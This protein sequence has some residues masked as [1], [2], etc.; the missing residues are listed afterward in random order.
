MAF[1]H[2]HLIDITEYSEEDIKLILETAKA[3]SEV[4]ER[5]IKKVP[6]LKGKTIVN[7]F[8]EPSTR[9]AAPSSSPR[10]AFRPTASTLAA[11]RPP[12]SR[13][14]ALS[15][16]SRPSTPIRS[17]ASLCATSTPVLPYIVTQNSPASVICAGDGKH[18]HPTQ[19]L[20]DLY[21]IWEHKGDFHGLKV[22]VVG[23][24]AH[25]RVCG[26]LIPALKIM[27][28][29]TYAVAP[30][31]AAAAGARGPGLRPR[32]ERP[33][34]R[35][36]RAGRRLHAARAAAGAPR[37]CPVPH[38]SRVP[39]ALRP[40]Q[41]PRE[42]HEARRDHLPPGPINRGVEF[43][44]YMADHP[45]RSVILEQV[46]AGICV[47]M[48]ILY[49]L[50]EVPIMALLLK[51]AHVVDPSVELDGVV[52][53]LIDGDKIAEVGENLAV[54]GAEVRDLSGKYLVPGLVDMHVHLREP[55]YEVKEDIESGTRAAAKGGFTG[56]CAMP[57]TDPVT[58]NG[59]VVEFVKSRAAEVG[60]CRVYPSGAMTRGLK[61]EAMS[62]MGDMV[63]HG[64]VAFTDD[65]RG[66][67]GA[68]MLRR[69]MDYG[70]M[71]G[72]VFMSHCRDEDLVGHGQ[73]NE[74][75][76]STR[77]A[78]EG[79]PA[80]GEELQIARDIEIAKLTGAKL[81]IQHIST[82][83]GLEIVRA[84]KA[85][86]V[87]VTCEA[88]PHHMFLTENDLDETY[89]TS[90]QGQPA[91]AYRGGCRGHSSGRH[92]RHRRRYRHRSRSPHPVGEGPRVRACALW[93]DRPRDLAVARTHRAGQ[94]GQDEHGPYGR[95]HGHQAA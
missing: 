17:T 55:G 76:V 12:R 20:L 81:H 78:L 11:P 29:E 62:E 19:A 59:T 83:H 40:D 35:P 27:G 75:K 91:A 6:T 84:G 88:T 51:N 41:G 43:D 39:Q 86:G 67:Q 47:R 71:F 1:N 18:N 2:K 28:C 24:I 50:L 64:A 45:Q 80:A 85:A 8:N 15:I 77:L 61:G 5:A 65:G 26:S 92:R 38:D 53:V 36:A 87:Q 4:N 79:W 60:H 95:A 48:A 93:H 72:K 89:N 9:T 42:A 16:P 58:D 46:Y 37:G 30:R 25:S 94:H 44:S 90:L 3:F 82:A 74:G 52:D 70:K 34:F 66:V 56:V 21:T 68:G 14:R 49:L 32:D 31:H 63:A 73:I 7:M 23:D 69:C 54:E 22:A 13:A 57:N 33:R 10:S